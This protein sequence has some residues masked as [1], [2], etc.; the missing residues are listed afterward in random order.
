MC[1]ISK[2]IPLQNKWYNIQARGGSIA[3]SRGCS[4]TPLTLQWLI[5]RHKQLVSKFL[6]YYKLSYLSLTFSSSKSCEALFV[7][8]YSLEGS[9]QNLMPMH[10]DCFIEVTT[11]FLVKMQS[12]SRLSPALP[13]ESP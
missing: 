6:V 8:H 4:S 12:P 2:Q 10:A 7:Q 11:L 5:H 1:G 9:K 3:G 13:L